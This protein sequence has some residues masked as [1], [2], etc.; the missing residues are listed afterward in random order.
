MRH[1]ASGAPPIEVAGF[2][3]GVA[4]ATDVAETTFATT[5][6]AIPVELEEEAGATETVGQ[7][8]AISLTEVAAGVGTRGA[9][10]SVRTGRA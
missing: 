8:V 1:L 3:V 4:Q 7:E 10:P 6:V 5:R 2:L 9:T